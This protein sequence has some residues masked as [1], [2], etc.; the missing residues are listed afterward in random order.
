MRFKL[1]PL[2]LVPLALQGQPSWHFSVESVFRGNTKL[3]R[4]WLPETA[5]QIK[6]VM[7]FQDN[8]AEPGMVLDTDLRSAAAG[9]GLGIVYCE[10][11]T[12]SGNFA[13]TPD[14][15]NLLALLADFAELTGIEELAY[16]PWLPVGH[17]ALGPMAELIAFWKP[18]R[19]IGVIHYKSGNLQNYVPDG[20]S[21]TDI[22]Q[23][24]F[25]V[26]NGQYEEYGPDGVHAAGDTWEEQWQAVQTDLA[27]WRSLAPAARLWHIVEA[28]SGH[29]SWTGRLSPLV[30]EFIGTSAAL[31]IP[32]AAPAAE[33]IALNIISEDNPWLTADSVQDVL[34]APSVDPDGGPVRKI[35][36]TGE[37]SRLDLSQVPASLA[38]DKT[39]QT[40]TLEASSKDEL[41]VHFLL[42]KGP[43]DQIGE[44]TF[45][46][47]AAKYRYN[48]RDLSGSRFAFLAWQDETPT[49]RYGER[50][51]EVRVNKNSGTAQTL[52]F[53]VLPD[54]EWDSGP[55][56]LNAS[57][58]SGLPVDYEVISGPATIVGSTLYLHRPPEA[59]KASSMP[60]II[61][62]GQ[63]GNA[64]YAAADSVSRTFMVAVPAP[65]MDRIEMW[66]H[67]ENQIHL[68]WASSSCFDQDLFF[69]LEYSS[70]LTPQGWSPVAGPTQGMNQ[71]TG[72]FSN[73]AFFRVLTSRTP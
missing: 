70:N 69:T 60:V 4:L 23:V 53:P 16:V 73:P 18:E 19:T 58:S 40:I 27:L 2:M 56:L 9:A 50:T 31:R 44:N 30:S 72:S 32:E 14:G 11:G 61:N 59:V 65:E 22:E 37:G 63:F 62:A 7:I 67:P 43:C 24:P 51:A 57:A 33:P 36:Y 52:T 64:S 12:F 20:K 46:L 8:W 28:G 13:A 34:P 42:E 38:Y 41:P 25:L 55:I 15:D 17:S 10:A 26:I 66:I 5:R 71:Y 1:L 35:T 48:G 3:V 68:D 54:A 45:R 6:G 39:T 47:N 49:T 29:F 21:I